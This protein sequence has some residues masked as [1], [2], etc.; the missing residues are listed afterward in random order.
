[1]NETLANLSCD[2]KRISY[3]I[4][5]EKFSLAKKFL[6]LAKKRYKINSK[7]GPFINFWDEVEKVEKLEGGKIRAAD[8]ATTLASILL[9]ESVKR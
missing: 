3:W 7:I 5:E 9:L 8:R 4:Y 1:M 6:T 2:L